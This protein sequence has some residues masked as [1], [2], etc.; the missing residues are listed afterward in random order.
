MEPLSHVRYK[1]LCTS[2]GHSYNYYSSVHPSKTTILF[3]HGFPYTANIWRHHIAHF[4]ELGYG[5]IAPDMLGLGASDKPRNA[6]DFASK[7]MAQS[8]VDILSAEGVDKAVVVG[9][10]WG[11]LVASRMAIYHPTRTL[12]L[13]LVAVP[14]WAPAPLDLEAVN[15]QTEQAFGFSI[16]GYW[17][18]FMNEKGLLEEHAILCQRS[19]NMEAAKGALKE[20]LINNNEC[21]VDD[22]VTNLERREFFANDWASATQYYHCYAEN[23][24]WEYEKDLSEKEHIIKVPALMVA[25]SDDACAPV[26]LVEST[27][28]NFADVKLVTISGG[29]HI[30]LSNVDGFNGSV[31]RFLGE[32]GIKATV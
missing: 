7:V 2:T 22:Y 13:I 18:V 11:S 23:F 28:A 14:Y 16:F 9:H 27:L 25:A 20:W 26:P 29:H 10:D 30:H 31:L 5:C 21:T 12:V 19:G 4:E 32:K 17:P 6:Q 15:D 24:N 3:A 8:M 1:K